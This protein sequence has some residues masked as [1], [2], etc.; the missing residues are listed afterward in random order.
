V[1]LLALI[2]KVCCITQVVVKVDSDDLTAFGTRFVFAA[3]T[4]NSLPLMKAIAHCQAVV[5]DFDDDG[6]DDDESSSSSSSSIFNREYFGA[7]GFR[8]CALFE[9][10]AV[11]SLTKLPA[12]SYVSYASGEGFDITVLEV[13]EQGHL[14]DA[15]QQ[16]FGDGNNDDYGSD[17][18]E[19][20][21]NVV[22]CSAAQYLHGHGVDSGNRGGG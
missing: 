8:P 15:N 4:N 3:P 18:D 14:T 19:E 9:Y 10:A 22:C 13:D 17:G 1:I 16:V 20:L 5:V 21:F 11:T 12:G 7:H 6:D 2:L